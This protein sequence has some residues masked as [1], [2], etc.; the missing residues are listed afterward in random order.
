[1]SLIKNIYVLF[2]I[3]VLIGLNHSEGFDSMLFEI[4]HNL[5]PMVLLALAIIFHTIYKKCA[6]K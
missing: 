4:K 6:H 3:I 5:W 2:I 1:M